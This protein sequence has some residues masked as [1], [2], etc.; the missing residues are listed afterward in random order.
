MLY[1]GKMAGLLTA[2]FAF[3]ELLVS[4]NSLI[5]NL[6]GSHSTLPVSLQHSIPGAQPIPL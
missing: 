2:V 4:V 6:Q 3:T 1:N 5:H